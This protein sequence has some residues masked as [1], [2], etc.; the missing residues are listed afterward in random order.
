[1]KFDPILPEERGRAMRAQGY[2]MDEL[3]IGHL[4]RCIAETPG[5]TAI[6]DFNSMLELGTRLTYVEFG[7]RVERIAV[8]L[9]ELGVGKNDVV[10]CQL[11]NWW[12][13][14]L[15]YLACSRIGAVLNPLMHRFLF[16]EAM[17]RAWVKHNV[18]EVGL[19]EH[20]VPLLYPKDRASAE[21][22]G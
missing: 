2:W 10:S 3:L 14:S 22:Q 20:I 19:L 6:V 9:A 13:F 15:M 17:G 7:K 1:M 16:G 4:D 18:E 12:Q 8:G 5:K 21:R 11:P